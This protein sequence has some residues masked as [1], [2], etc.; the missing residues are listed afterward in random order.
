MSKNLGNLILILLLAGG[1]ALVGRSLYLMVFSKPEPAGL[2]PKVI[3]ELKKIDAFDLRV[4]EG[5]TSD[6][7]FI[8]QSLK[9]FANQSGPEAVPMI[10]KYLVDTRPQVLAAALDVAGSYANPEFFDALKTNLFAPN[11][12]V[13]IGALNGIAR[14]GH[15]ERLELMREYWAKTRPDAEETLY[16]KLTEL[17]LRQDEA[18]RTELKKEI[19][20]DVGQ[21]SPT[22]QT[23]I[24]EELYKQM[25]GDVQLVEKARELL[26]RPGFDRLSSRMLNFERSFDGAWLKE[27]IGTFPLH[28]DYEYQLVLLDYLSAECPAGAASIAEALSQKKNKQVSLGEINKANVKKRCP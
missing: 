15:P 11:K 21:A 17:K 25:P 23:S 24:L 12:T 27:N 22:V 18:E 7:K 26:P 13:R 16:A 14:R 4:L 19:I 1:A 10:K 20:A 3:A 6:E 28:D 9:R 2:D 8:V 5:G